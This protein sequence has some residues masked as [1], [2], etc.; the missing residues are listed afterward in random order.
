MSH[1]SR[2]VKTRKET[3]SAEFRYSECRPG[4]DNVSLREVTLFGYASLNFHLD[5]TRLHDEVTL[6]V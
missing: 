6:V 2:D 3:Q 1:E 4:I 5:G